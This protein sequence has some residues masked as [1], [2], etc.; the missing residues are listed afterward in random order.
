MWAFNYDQIIREVLINNK[1]ER[2]LITH[3]ADF[4]NNLFTFYV[5]VWIN[6][7]MT[8]LSDISKVF[9]KNI[10]KYLHKITTSENYNDFILWSE[11]NK[12]LDHS[13]SV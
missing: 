8:T 9:N 11:I 7:K 10:S 3:I 4:T 1:I 5:S 13:R 2:I 6:H 12:H